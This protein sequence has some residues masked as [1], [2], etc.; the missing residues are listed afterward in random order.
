M[1]EHIEL[2]PEQRQKLIDMAHNV[3]LPHYQRDRFVQSVT[4]Y[5]D[6]EQKLPDTGTL[7]ALLKEATMVTHHGHADKGHNTHKAMVRAK[8]KRKQAKQSRRKNR[9]KQ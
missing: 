1:E 3:Q 2:D 6:T 8:S 4:Q 9:G 7:T 5:I